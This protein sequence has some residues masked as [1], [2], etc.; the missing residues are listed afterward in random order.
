M[1]RR[2]DPVDFE[3]H[4][5]AIRAMLQELL[6]SGETTLYGRQYTYQRLRQARMPVI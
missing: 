6:A 5:Q 4:N 2:F 1:R 3:S